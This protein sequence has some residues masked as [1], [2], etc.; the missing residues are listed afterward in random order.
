M[1]LTIEL[2]ESQ[3]KAAEVIKSLWLESY[4]L[5]VVSALFEG[6]GD[7]DYFRVHPELDPALYAWTR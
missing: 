6:L 2:I 3:C 5:V 7:S 4:L 1:I